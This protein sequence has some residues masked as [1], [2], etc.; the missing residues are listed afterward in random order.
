MAIKHLFIGGGS[1]YGFSFFGILKQTYI[2]NVWS[3]NNIETIH[4]ISAG[5]MI[6]TMISLNLEWDVL[7]DYLVNRPWEKLFQMNMYSVINSIQNRGIFS[8]VE[9]QEIFKPLF[10]AKDLSCDIT[11]SEFYDYTKIEHN[12]IVTKINADTSKLECLSISH[13]THPDWKVLDVVYMSSC[14]P[15]LFTPTFI[16]GDIYL[17]GIF[18]VKKNIMMELC[19]PESVPDTA[20]GDTIIKEDELLTI[21]LENIKLNPLEQT[22]SLFDYLIQLIFYF[23]KYDNEDVVVGNNNY[24]INREPFNLE[25]YYLS[26]SNKQE[27]VRLINL[28][29]NAVPKIDGAGGG[30]EGGGGVTNDEKLADEE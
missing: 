25:Q 20:N 29:I 27:R 23:I 22:S 26:I 19:V 11:M 6:G 13:K 15:I 9:F 5:S 10:L 30:G 21:S 1:F 8:K 17:D 28:G 7:E 4:G 2:N 24:V 3:L 16:N 12:Y 18:S 14:L